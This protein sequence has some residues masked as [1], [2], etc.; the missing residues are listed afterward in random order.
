MNQDGFITMLEG[1]LQSIESDIQEIK[2][3]VKHLT[4]F[5]IRVAAIAL[6]ISG[7]VSFLTPIILKFF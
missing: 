3:D 6:C 5:K 1:R 4:G 2:R 7:I